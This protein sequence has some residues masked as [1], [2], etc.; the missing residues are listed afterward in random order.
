MT[1]SG[2]FP[3]LRALGL[4]SHPA[5]V[6]Q[7]LAG[8]LCM[9]LVLRAVDL[10]RAH[11]LPPSQEHGPTQLAIPRAADISIIQNARLFGGTDAAD[12][13]LAAT[14][15]LVLAGVIA[16][17]DPSR[18]MA[19]LG[20]AAGSLAIY[21]AGEEVS[22]GSRLESVFPTYVLLQ[23]GGRIERLDMQALQATIGIPMLV[24][25]DPQEQRAAVARLQAQIPLEP[26]KVLRTQLVRSGGKLQGYRIYP[27]SAQKPFERSGLQRGDVVVSVNGHA[28]ADPSGQGDLLTVLR[29]NRRARV[30]IDR[31]G[32][33]QELLINL[34]DLST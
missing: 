32:V 25:S 2:F 3:R 13:P 21:R 1:V 20:E 31:N 8:L 10:V 22:N 16:Y 28:A 7:L 34:D 26:G 12:A 33:Q 27:G 11:K 14:S 18:G 19:M 6:P 23:R 29:A 30:V 9:L 24:S 15:G 17:P 5:R 4:L